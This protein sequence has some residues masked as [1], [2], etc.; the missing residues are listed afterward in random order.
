MI[1][2]AKSMR[3]QSLPA[4]S[5]APFPTWAR[6]KLAPETQ[7]EAAFLAGAALA[8]LDATLRENPPWAGA[9]RR[10]L[11]LGAAAATASQSGRA[12]DEAALRDAFHLTRPGA[13]PGPAG[14]HLLA[15]RTLTS[16]SAG[17]WRAAIAV[18]AE[19]LE[20]R[21]DEA[22][23]TA[24]DAAEACRTSPRL[25]PFAAARAYHL[26]RRALAPAE[27]RAGEGEGLA[28]FLADVVLAQK[29]G[30]PIASPLLAEPLFSQARRRMALDVDEG[31][32]T[33]RVLFAYAQAAEKACDLA[34]DLGRRAQKL[35]EAAPKLR[36]KGAGAA[37][38]ALLDDDSVSAT[39]KI[40]GLSERGARRLL[41]RLVSLGA[42]RELTGRTTFRL[43]GL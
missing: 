38:D 28:A 40:P 2:R 7:A 19:A 26:A 32:E 43:Y 30:W 31:A 24:I 8:R 34:A 22:L 5:P 20:V 11:A 21:R 16:G 37:L 27:G 4:S 13:D 17:Q 12:E 18:A 1:E 29:L 39:T 23:Q 41:E 33:L 10:R 15:W 36:A 9:F 35:S 3:L 14:R 25:A 42:L 6:T